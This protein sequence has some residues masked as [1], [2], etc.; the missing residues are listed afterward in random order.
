[1]LLRGLRQALDSQHWC[2][3]A[4]GQ[5]VDQEKIDL[6]SQGSFNR[7]KQ[8]SGCLQEAL[9]RENYWFGSVQGRWIDK[10]SGF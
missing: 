6:A 9:D 3:G 4:F 5:A 8:C 1:M 2:G 10:N 7:Q